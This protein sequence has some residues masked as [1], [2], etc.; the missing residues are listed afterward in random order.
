L[1]RLRNVKFPNIDPMTEETRNE[2]I[3]RE[4]KGIL[5][6]RGYCAGA[7][8]N[9][10]DLST[11]SKPFLRPISQASIARSRCLVLPRADVRSGTACVTYS[12]TNE[13]TN[14][15]G[16]KDPVRTCVAITAGLWRFNVLAFSSPDPTW[17]SHVDSYPKFKA[18]SMYTVLLPLLLSTPE[19][20]L[21]CC[22]PTWGTHL[23]VG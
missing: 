13:W 7:A 21:E 8:T 12:C 1:E 18:N 9:H 5:G 4:T 11:H 19:M 10:T 2:K 20:E 14:V 6:I 16:V 22:T 15:N 17:S 23:L 3:G